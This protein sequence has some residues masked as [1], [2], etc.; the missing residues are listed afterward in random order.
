ME[1][2]ASTATLTLLE[3]KDKVSRRI[4]DYIMKVRMSMATIVSQSS[5]RIASTAAT[6]A[7]LFRHRHS[8]AIKFMLLFQ[9][10]VVVTDLT[11]FRHR[12]RTG[13]TPVPLRQVELVV[14]VSDLTRPV[15]EALLYARSLGPPM[16]AV[17]ID[18]VDRQRYRVPRDW[19]LG[20]YGRST[21]RAHKRFAV[22][23]SH[24]PSRGL[25]ARTTPGIATGDPH[26]RGHPRIHR[27][28]SLS[29][30]P[31]YNQTGLAMKGVPAKEPRHAVTSVPS[32][33]AH[34]GK[35][36]RSRYQ[37]IQAPAQEEKSPVASRRSPVASR[38]SPVACRLS[39]VAGRRSPVACRPVASQ[40][41]ALNTA[42]SPSQ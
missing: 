2:D 24:R 8:L 11:H 15:R 20:E 25:P 30:I 21:R 18:V 6:F 37:A 7:A 23:R 19:G 14:P 41:S 9:S 34:L 39:P 1:G 26:Q 38:L 17:H 40:I 42:S 4:V 29:P 33:P 22:S 16:V 28:G 35:G 10:G 12:R 13:L 32:T 31:P 5:C 27:E 3:G 36:G